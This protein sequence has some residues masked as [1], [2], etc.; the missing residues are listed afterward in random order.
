MRRRFAY[1]L[2][3]GVLSSGAPAGLLGV[4]LAKAPGEGVSLS[5]VRSELTADRS[6]Y[7]YIGG[8]TALIFALFGY[9]LGRQ[10]D[11]LEQ[12]SETDP[13]TDLLNARGFS[14]SLQVEIKR[15]RRYRQP[16]SLLFLDLDG[17]KNINDRHGHR[18]GSDALRQVAAVIRSEMR[19][20]DTGARWGGDEFTIL[21]PNTSRIAALSFAERVR[22]RISEQRADWPLTVSIGVATLNGSENVIPEDGAT[23]VRSADTAMYQAK[24]A[25]KNT[26]VAAAAFPVSEKPEFGGLTIARRGLQEAARAHPV[27]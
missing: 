7:L 10:A 8:A 6:S 18:A 21:A 24:R 15:A 12:L 26:V 14:A 23:L 27:R 22:V 9:Y 16:L 11:R 3:A 1:A 2:T 17:L 19:E 13:L 5:Q 20:T 4:R 25:G